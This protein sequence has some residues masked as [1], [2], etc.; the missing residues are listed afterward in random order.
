MSSNACQLLAHSGAPASRVLLCSDTNQPGWLFL[1][2]RN[3]LKLARLRL[4]RHTAVVASSDAA[5][6]ALVCRLGLPG[7]TG[8]HT[9]AAR[10]HR[11]RSCFRHCDRRRLHC[12][13]SLACAARQRN[14]VGSWLRLEVAEQ[15]L[16]L[17]APYCRDKSVTSRSAR[18]ILANMDLQLTLASSNQR[19]LI[20]SARCAPSA[21]NNAAR[22][23][24]ARRAT[25]WN[26]ASS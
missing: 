11:Y 1:R 3:L 15:L 4:Q 5:R 13:P 20:L 24:P 26:R 8:R 18:L 19:L 10:T 25:H 16:R 7:L 21:S 2:S 9:L 14:M 23:E 6:A 22:D 12:G 17:G